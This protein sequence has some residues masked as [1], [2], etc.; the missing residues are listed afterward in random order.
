MDRVTSKDGTSIAYERVGNGP[1]VIL[2]GGAIDDGSENAPL[3]PELAEHFT[4]V[5]YARRGRGESGD[6]LPYAVDREIEDVEALIA[7]SGGSAQVFGASSGGALALEA[8][9]AGLAIDRLAVYEVPYNMDD[10][11]PHW[12]QGDVS[13]VEALLVEGRRDDVV[14]LFMRT[15]GS[16]EEDIAG[17]K[18][19]PFWPPL[20]G[21]A[22]TLAYDAACM[23]DGPLPAA[24]LAKITQPTLVATG[25]G[26]PDPH[27]A[28]LPHGF[29]DRAA[30][31]IAA[32][33]PLAQR[34]IIE[35]GGHMVDAKLVAPVLERFFR[36]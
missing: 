25:G 21:L 4:V 31:A 36:G 9:A 11:G 30:D 14:E 8:A 2:V 19:S 22:H 35:G 34:Q 13:K 17:A 6:T 15:V 1:T 32:S 28:G 3:V 5:N 33:I 24:R 10:D 23:G 27:A 20:E 26:T 16:S 7:E 12:N 18:G 29:M